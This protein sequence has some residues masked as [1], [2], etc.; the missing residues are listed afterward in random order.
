MQVLAERTCKAFGTTNASSSGLPN[1]IVSG[2]PYRKNLFQSGVVNAR[3]EVFYIT[4]STTN[5][6]RQTVAAPNLKDQFRDLRHYWKSIDEPASIKE[7]LKQQLFELT[8]GRLA[9][10]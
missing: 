8:L 5:A 10:L 6:A 4:A 2:M 9:H 1:E 7:R 3:R